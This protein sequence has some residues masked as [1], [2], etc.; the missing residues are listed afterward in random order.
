MADRDER[1][2]TE[3]LLGERLFE[4]LVDRD[5][6]APPGWTLGW[7]ESASDDDPTQPYLATAPDGTV[8]EVEVRVTLWARPAVMPDA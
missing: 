8:Y 3:I 6:Y 2:E 5:W 1:F 7:D 4:H